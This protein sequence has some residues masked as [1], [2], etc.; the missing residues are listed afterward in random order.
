[1]VPANI[2]NL[3]SSYFLT[4]D[5]LKG[6]W[7]AVVNVDKRNII[8]WSSNGCGIARN[9]CLAAPG[10]N[11]LS[12]FVR[13]DK[14][15]VKDQDAAVQ[16]KKQ[17]GD[18]NL[19]EDDGYGT[20][21]RTSMAAPVVTGALAVIKSS[22]PSLTAREAV[23]ILLCTATDLDKTLNCPAKSIEEC[24]RKGVE[25]THDNGWEPSEVYGHGLVNL[26]RA[27][28][29]IGNTNTADRSGRVVA[30]TG[31][32]RIAFSAA[33]GNT[34]SSTKHLFGGLDSY[35]RVY[36][37]R[38]PLQDRMLP[39]PRLSG[40]LALN[41]PAQSH[42]IG[43]TRDTATYLR[44]STDPESAIGDGSALSIIGS[45]TRIDLA[46]ARRRTSSLLS[47]AALLAGEKGAATASHDWG[48]LAPQSRDLVSGGAAWQL[49][50]RLSA[51]TYVSR[52]LAEGATQRGESY[53][54]T[55]LGL[56]ARLGSAESGF[57]LHL[58]R[59]SEEGRFLGSKPEGGYALAGP[60]R[61]YYLRLSAS[62]RVNN[63]LSVGLNMMRLRAKV[64]FRHDDFV[65]DTDINARSAGVHL[66]LSDAAM[67]GDRLVLHYGESL[68]VTG[69]AIRQSSVMGYTAARAYKSETRS[70]DLGVRARHRM[71]Q[72]MYRAPLADGITGFAAAAHN[73]NWSHQRGRGNNLVM[74][75]LTIR[76]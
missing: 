33:F 27:V 16:T 76:H 28:Q 63:R 13:G 73:R 25:A 68:A 7:L 20:Y 66:A 1:M 70:L 65:A 47:P 59:L 30:A 26:A 3:E 43:R 18:V 39:G 4:N 17:T 31:T 32:T 2:P 62:H 8:H 38:A 48:V 72:V 23:E 42:L 6:S 74:F 10:T 54:M 53:G 24:S 49:S 57:A 14:D 36:R 11:I 21:T 5:R 22:A 40:V 71:A 58:G 52:A 15:D 56:S 55:D 41:S 29:S 69:G 61:S 44:R 67:T 45:K 64:D 46:V 19:N 60:T 50:P 37:Y 34:A 9:Y 51:G 35:G 75:G 12:T